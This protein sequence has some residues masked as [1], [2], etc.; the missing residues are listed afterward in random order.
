MGYGFWST[1]GRAIAIGTNLV[2]LEKQALRLGREDLISDETFMMA[3]ARWCLR[4]LGWGTV[5]LESYLD[6][7]E[8]RG[9]KRMYNTNVKAWYKLIKQVFERDDYTCQYCGQ[10]GG[11]LEADHIIAFSKGGSDKLENLI[12]ACRKCNRQKRDK[13]VE[14]F[15][16][17]KECQN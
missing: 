8:S 4:E 10:I 5:S 2:Y 6:H 11:K 12:T 14:E 17:W 15:L 16:I 1:E 9:R 13:T 3:A 7:L